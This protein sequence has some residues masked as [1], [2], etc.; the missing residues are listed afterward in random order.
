MVDSQ[1]QAE[2][3]AYTIPSS[4]SSNFSSVGNQTEQKTTIIPPHRV[5]I[6]ILRAFRKEYKTLFEKNLKQQKVNFARQVK[7]MSKELFEDH[8]LTF[9]DETFKNLIDLLDEDTIHL[10]IQSMSLLVL[11]DR[12]KKKDKV[13]EGLDFSELNELLDKPNTR[14]TVLFF[15]QKQN[16]LLYV[17]FFLME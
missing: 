7:K 10:L 14:K 15:S 16:A 13:M 5:E 9:I 6:K 12:H 2:V 17:F 8:L 1:N 11:K 3:E 4:K